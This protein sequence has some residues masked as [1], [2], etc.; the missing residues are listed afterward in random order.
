MLQTSGKYKYGTFSNKLGMCNR[1][2]MKKTFFQIIF[3]NYSESYLFEEPIFAKKSQIP[4]KKLG[5]KV[6]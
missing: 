4:S 2:L 5:E 1:S 3:E 6:I